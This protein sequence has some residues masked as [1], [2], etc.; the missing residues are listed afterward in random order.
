MKC[1]RCKENELH[2]DAAMNALSRRDNKTYICS[3]CGVR[4]AIEGEYFKKRFSRIG[5]K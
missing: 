5:F 4:E 2:E 1:P 3:D